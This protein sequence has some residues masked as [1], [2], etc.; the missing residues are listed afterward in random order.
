MWSLNWKPL[1][2]S[3][4]EH[5]SNLRVYY[6]FYFHLLKQYFIKD[7]LFVGTVLSLRDVRPEDS[8]TF[9]LIYERVL[10]NT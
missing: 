7:L 6:K 2:F 4:Y 3:P 1:C 8:E 10:K 5:S 9:S